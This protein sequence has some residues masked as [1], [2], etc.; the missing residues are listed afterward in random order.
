VPCK[1]EKE[2]K[3]I[4]KHLIQKKLIACA[5]IVP[6]SSIYEWE[7]K[8]KDEKEAI[9][10]IKTL[11]RC[12]EQVKEEIKNVHSYDIPAIIRLGGRVNEEYLSWMESVIE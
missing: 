10:L 6:S 4:A 2:A 9:L 11:D 5:N 8:I 3:K 1:D 7:G 12:E